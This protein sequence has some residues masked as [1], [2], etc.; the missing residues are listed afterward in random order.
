[1]SSHVATYSSLR[2]HRARVFFLAGNTQHVESKVVRREVVR[3]LAALGAL[4]AWVAV[5]TLL[6]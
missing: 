6:G 3:A 2:V 1:M 4:A 5:V